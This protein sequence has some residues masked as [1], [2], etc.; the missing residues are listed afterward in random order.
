MRWSCASAQ[1]S[2]LPWRTYWP[3]STVRSHLLAYHLRASLI[4][5]INGSWTQPFRGGGRLASGDKHF[6][7]LVLDRRRILTA[8]AF[9]DA[10]IQH[11]TDRRVP[12]FSSI[13]T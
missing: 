13:G 2:Y 7:G 12:W 1:T 4:R 11:R 8:R 9:L 3:K 6:L 10:H 5:P